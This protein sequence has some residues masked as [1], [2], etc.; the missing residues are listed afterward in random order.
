M[1]LRGKGRV[2][3]T[4]RVALM[5]I[6]HHVQKVS[7]SCSTLAT[8][9]TVARQAP[10]SMGFSRQEYWSGLPF[11]SSG[12]LPDPGIKPRS[13]ALQADSLLTEPPGH[14]QEGICVYIQLRHFVSQQKLTLRFSSH[15]YSQISWWMC[16][17]RLPS[18]PW[19][20]CQRLQGP[21]YY[22]IFV[23]P[24]LGVPLT[25][26]LFLLTLSSFSINYQDFLSLYR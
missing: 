12:D 14:S 11:P 24:H 15:L 25:Q 2:G 22:F 7:K 9:W 19:S 16:I 21:W 23:L 10:L 17:D 13:P 1:D 5:Y 6:H 18:R 20:L 4:G 26:E 3:R 8:W